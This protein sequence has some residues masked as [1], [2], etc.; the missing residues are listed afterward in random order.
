MPPD[1]AGRD[2]S[3]GLSTFR[4]SLEKAVDDINNKYGIPS[5]PE[6][7]PP[8]VIHRGLEQDSPEGRDRPFPMPISFPL[9][10]FC[11][12]YQVPK[13][14]DA[15]APKAKSTV[16]EVRN[17]SSTL[18]GE[19]DSLGEEDIAQKKDDGGC[20]LPTMLL[21]EALDSSFDLGELMA[22]KASQNASKEAAPQRAAAENRDWSARQSTSCSSPRDSIHNAAWE[23][24]EKAN[25]EFVPNLNGKSDESATEGMS[26]AFPTTSSSTYESDSLSL[27]RRTPLLPTHQRQRSNSEQ[28]TYSGR[29]SSLGNYDRGSLSSDAGIALKRVRARSTS[30]NPE[31]SSVIINSRQPSNTSDGIA[32]SDDS[33]PS[34]SD[35]VRKFRRMGSLPGE[36]PPTSPVDAH[37]QFPAIRRISR[38]NQFE[39]F[40]NRFS[41]DSEAS[42]VVSSCPR[43]LMTEEWRP[44]G[45]PSMTA[46]EVPEAAET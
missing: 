19:S 29:G 31:C 38:G 6:S 33:V 9:S 34:V 16:G 4:A 27:A 22:T 3:S 10:N 45:H 13:F 36:F 8:Y 25:V 37:K 42:S 1:L 39:S 24:N 32:F 30:D 26:N 7:C 15:P 40:R 11:P 14:M 23:A 17:L 44:E 35:L 2:K 18:S 12:R 43:G 20:H 5:S 28:A 21:N 46:R 41:S